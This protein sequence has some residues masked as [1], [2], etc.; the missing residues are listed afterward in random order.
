VEVATG[1]ADGATEPVEPPPPPR[2][3][4]GG[5][6]RK[7]AKTAKTAKDASED[8]GTATAT[9]TQSI[10][11]PAP[12]S[13]TEEPVLPAAAASA[14]AA[15]AAAASAA[16]A[17]AAGG[18]AGAAGVA[19]PAGPAGV[20][21]GT[22]DLAH[23]VEFAD[24]AGAADVAPVA[25]SRPAVS[26]ARATPGAF[27]PRSAGRTPAVVPASR[28]IAD[29]PS[30]PAILDR[31]FG[32]LTTRMPLVIGAAVLALAVVVGGVGAYLLLP[33]AT[34]VITPREASI[35]PVELRITADPSITEPDQAG[36]VVPA[37]TRDVPVEASQ[38]FNVT[39]K[40]VQEVPAKGTVRFDNYDTSS[41]NTIARGSIVS[42]RSGVQFRTD[43]AVTIEAA[44]YDLATK[45]F[46]P[47]TA[48]AAI[49]A[50]DPGTAGNVDP[51]TIT[52]VPRGE[53]GRLLDVTNPNATKG[54][55]REEFPRVAQADIDAATAALREQLTTNFQDKLADPSLTEDGTTAFPE[56]A[57]LGD[58]TFTVEPSSLLGDEVAKFDLGAAAS[59]TV[60]A[61]D[62]SAVEA[63]AAADIAT[64]V[65]AGYS[66]VE[67]SSNVDPSPGTVDGGMITFPVVITAREVLQ[68]D[69][70]AIEQEIRGKTLAEAQT[71]LQ[72]YGAADLT[73][74]PDWVGTVPTL[75]ARVDVR[76]A[77]A[78]PA[79]PATSAP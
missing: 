1:P 36:K 26:S 5:S 9:S 27:E 49:T 64:H 76:T 46:T 52:R 71:I 32:P 3:A 6:R 68:L 39:G 30:R 53:S 31:P 8:T 15:S 75:D 70:A 7:T 29:T 18:V 14:A 24:A 11:A 40:R 45:K 79:A 48:T 56:T 78:E 13:D 16:A 34:V 21:A 74:W 35:G 37:L 65:E 10:W 12:A 4:R 47:G 43:R 23:A 22:S 60:L 19:G 77:A 69:T 17:S 61:V 20:A 59:G 54:G 50:V 28:V 73:V 67:G 57:S 42:T 44:T 33:T 51:N 41:S 58:P 38:T 25:S 55:K 66:L 63:V 2:T 62:E 72:R